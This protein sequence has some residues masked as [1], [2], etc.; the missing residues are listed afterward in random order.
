M[1]LEY[2]PTKKKD[3]YILSKALS[4]NKFKF[5]RSKIEATDNPFLIEREC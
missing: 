1:S 4:R 2:I 3:A 5:H